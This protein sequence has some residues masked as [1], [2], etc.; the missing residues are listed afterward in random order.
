MTADRERSRE[1]Q[2]FNHTG[3]FSS[4]TCLAASDFWVGPDPLRT[5][6]DQSSKDL[7]FLEQRLNNLEERARTSHARDL[8][9]EA[10]RS[11][12]R[13]E[14]LLQDLT[15]TNDGGSPEQGKSFEEME[16]QFQ[17]LKSFRANLA[18]KPNE[19]KVEAYTLLTAYQ[20]LE[21]KLDGIHQE[22][23]TRGKTELAE[24][25][26]QMLDEI[27]KGMSKAASLARQFSLT[28]EDS[29]KASDLFQKIEGTQAQIRNTLSPFPKGE[30]TFRILATSDLAETFIIPLLKARSAGESFR[31]ENGDWYYRAGSEKVIV[32]KVDQNPF[33]QLSRKACDL[34]FTDREPS[35]EEKQAFSTSFG[36][37]RLDSLSTG[38]VVALDALTLLC[39]PESSRTS[40]VPEDLKSPQVFLSGEEGS[41]ERLAAERFGFRVTKTTKGLPAN[42]ILHEPDAIGL[43]LYH[44]EGANIRAK[45]LAWKAGPT[46]LELKPSPFTVATK[47]TAFRFGSRLGTLRTQ[48]R[49]QLS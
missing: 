2:P 44:R 13:S 18:T 4:R 47:I 27:G 3:H 23:V 31:A 37:A 33:E 20:D 12:A 7:S 35:P 34:L 14:S 9:A 16:R 46:T 49:R 1:V 5:A 40:M 6:V 21:A 17:D 45:R 41:P 11:L 26:E 22:A 38:K 29:K 28:P 36:G 25:A 48:S 24:Q 8:I 43:G 10:S 32:R 42:A 15:R 39:H 19:I 30:A